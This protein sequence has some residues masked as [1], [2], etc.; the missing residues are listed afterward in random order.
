MPASLR[1]LTLNSA[2]EGKL[3]GFNQPLGDCVDGKGDVFIVI[4]QSAQVREYKHGAKG[5]LRC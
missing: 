2:S 3:T 5:P 4:S 1:I